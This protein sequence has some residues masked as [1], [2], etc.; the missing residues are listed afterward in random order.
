MPKPR[1]PKQV[2]PLCASDDE[3]TR[4]LIDEVW[5]FRCD[6]SRDTHPYE[7]RPHDI[8]EAPLYGEEGVGAEL[9]VYDDLLAIA[10]EGFAE[11]GVLEYRFWKR[12]PQTYRTLVDRYGHTAFGP[13]RYTASAFLAGS[14][15]LLWKEE[16]IYGTSSRATGYWSYN[17]RIGA[18]GPVGTSETADPL[19]WER[20]ATVTLHTDPYDWPPLNY[21]AAAP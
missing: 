18:Y 4:S 14:L 16:L 3:V 19:S 11:Y 12:V 17:E 13:A 9:G 1:P 7:W 21:R 5:V 8:P 6:A 2:C 10:N 20:F 15:A